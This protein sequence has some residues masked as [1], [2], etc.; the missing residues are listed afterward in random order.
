MSVTL[1]GSLVQSNRN[2]GGWWLGNER[3]V[4]KDVVSGG[5]RSDSKGGWMNRRLHFE[6]RSQ[7][8]NDDGKRSARVRDNDSKRPRAVEWDVGSG[9]ERNAKNQGRT[10]MPILPFG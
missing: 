1:T 10:L 3:T 2:L 4:G 6:P 8:A 5:S 7:Q 9:F